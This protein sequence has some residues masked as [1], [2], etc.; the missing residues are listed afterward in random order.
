RRHTARRGRP[1]LPGLRAFDD[2]ACARLGAEPRSAKNRRPAQSCLTRLYRTR[3]TNRLDRLTVCGDLSCRI[4]SAAP[5]PSGLRHDN[6]AN[7][8]GTHRRRNGTKLRHRI[9]VAI[10]KHVEGHGLTHT[11]L[12]NGG[13][14]GPDPIALSARTRRHEI[15]VE[16]MSDLVLSTPVVVTAV[17]AK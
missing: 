10:L 4:Q 1:Q 7:P 6:H 5:T 3:L 9:A 15:V 8:A 12:A 17:T 13:A 16:T 2:G 11:A 14:I